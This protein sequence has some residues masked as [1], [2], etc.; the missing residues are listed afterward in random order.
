[1]APE[2]VSGKGYNIYA[3]LWSLGIIM[4]EFMVNYIICNISNKILILFILL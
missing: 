1:M 4:Y 3:D 2:V